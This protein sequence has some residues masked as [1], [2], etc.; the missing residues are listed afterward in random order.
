MVN[1]SNG[2]I[3]KLINNVDNEIYVGS[4]V[5]PLSKRKGSHVEKS[6]RFPLRK[7]YKHLL[8]IGWNN[9]S[10]IL[11]ESYSCKNKDELTAREQ[12][13][14]E[15]LKPTL[16]DRNS[17]ETMDM[18]SIRKKQAKNNAYIKNKED[19]LKANKIYRD[20]TDNYKKKITCVCGSIISNKS[21]GRHKKRT[22]H[23]E[24]VKNNNYIE[25]PF[26]KINRKQ[27]VICECG[28]SLKRDTYGCSR[29]SNSKKHKQYLEI[30][31]YIYS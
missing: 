4:T 12:H 24:W 21:L 1:Y 14:I 31:N 8:K 16:N 19:V 29:H 9:I 10:I 5:V 18:Y 6:R 30:Y 25:P 7:I 20:A 15:I 28:V 2:K 3:Y 13:W 26:N 23:L 27:I 22:F 11:V 17:Y